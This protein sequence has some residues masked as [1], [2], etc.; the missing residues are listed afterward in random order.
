[1]SE[2]REEELRFVAKHYKKGRLDTRAAWRRLQ[3][4]Q[5]RPS[6]N[7][8]KWVAVAASVALAIGIAVACVLVNMHRSPSSSILMPKDSVRVEP[9]SVAKK[10]SVDSTKVFHFQDE[11]INQALEEVARYYGKDLMASDTTK[12]ISGDI[13]AE[14]IEEAAEVIGQTLNITI[15]IR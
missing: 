4:L 12:H 11:P 3:M 8:R 6:G 5:G 7:H 15:S 1:M 14:S 9:D 10:I 2:I 13:Q